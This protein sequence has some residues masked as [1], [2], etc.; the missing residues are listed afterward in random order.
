LINFLI[1]GDAAGEG[2]KEIWEEWVFVWCFFF[3]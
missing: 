2:R 1:F 3:L